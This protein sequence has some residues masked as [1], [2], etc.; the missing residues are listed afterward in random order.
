VLLGVFRATPALFH[1]GWFVESLTTQV[2]VLFVIRTARS[3]LRS[4]P[5]RAF[6]ATALVALAAGL[7]LPFTGVGALV[8]LVPLG[9]AFYAFVAA[10][11]AAYLVL[12]EV[13]KR[14]VMPRLVA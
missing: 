14:R 4:R 5:S 11:A 6:A 3:P 2:L 1:T 12:V 10:A 7:V 8:G 9:G 13:V